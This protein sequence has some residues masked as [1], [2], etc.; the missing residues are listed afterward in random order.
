[1]NTKE[2]NRILNKSKT[3]GKVSKRKKKHSGVTNEY[4]HR[5]L[6]SK[7]KNLSYSRTKTKKRNLV[8]N[9]KLLLSQNKKA[10]NKL[11]K[12]SMI[13]KNNPNRFE[14]LMNKIMVTHNL[15]NKNNKI[16][17]KNGL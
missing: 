12:K 10:R 9:R 6:N 2:F 13:K 4:G 8:K 11:R 16:I 7:I 15:K 1:M 14:R 17:V 3:K 5:V